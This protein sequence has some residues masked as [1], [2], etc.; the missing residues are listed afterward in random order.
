MQNKSISGDRQKNLKSQFYCILRSLKDDNYCVKMATDINKNGQCVST[1]SHRT[2]MKA[3]HH[4]DEHCHLA[5]VMNR[6]PQT[7][8]RVVESQYYFPPVNPPNSTTGRA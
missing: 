4:I 1:A 3:K 6:F 7:N 8:D 5:L 2:K